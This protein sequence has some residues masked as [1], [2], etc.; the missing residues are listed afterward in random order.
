MKLQVK[1]LW[2]VPVYCGVSSWISFYIT[3][4]LGQFFFVVMEIGTD[5]VISV[6]VDPV[7]SAIFNGILF[8]VVLLVGGL[9]AFRNMTK[10][11]IIASSAI[12]SAMYLLIVL[13]QLMIT[14]FPF[15]LILAYIQNWI[16][17]PN[18]FIYS[19][20]DNLAISA[21]ISS[22]SPLLFMLF[23][24]RRAEEIET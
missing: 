4:Y 17:V 19:M 11:E 10:Q 18:S 7:R 20:T 24:R 6:S 22:F 14:G 16:S 23:G 9:W 2:K 13:C 15:P 3:A 5:G 8:L 12:A 21:I 1:N